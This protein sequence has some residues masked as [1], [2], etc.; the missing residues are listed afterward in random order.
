ML[1]WFNYYGLIAVVIIMIPNIVYAFKHKDSFVNY[2]S[3]KFLIVLEQVGRYGCILFMIFNIP[4]TWFGFFFAFAEVIYLAVNSALL[5]TYVLVWI[6]LWN[7]DSV[8]RALILSAIPSL[9][10][11]FSGIMILSVPLIVAA[12]IFAA[13]HITLSLTN[14]FQNIKSSTN[15]SIRIKI[16]NAQEDDLESILKLQYLAYQS[17]AKLLNDMDIPPLKQ[18]LQEVQTEYKSGIILKALNANDKIVGSVRVFIKNDTVHIGKLI[19][20]PD[21]RRKG[22]GTKL[23]LEIEIR[24]PDYRYELFT[25][26]QSVSNLS[27]YQSLGYKIFKEESVKNG[28]KFIYL[29][30]TSNKFLPQ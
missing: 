24:F 21:F 29:E 18:T 22:I 19:V 14:A 4:Y 23:L 12:T 25:S 10:F 5:L 6:I 3:N 1:N 26:T 28:L 2:C 11:F 27:L 8:L 30:K 7:K 20:H 9:L 17:E 16:V 13:G 15:D